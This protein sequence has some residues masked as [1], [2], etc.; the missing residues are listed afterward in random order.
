LQP[1]AIVLD[2]EMQPGMDGFETC[3]RIREDERFTYIPI[4][5]VSAREAVEDSLSGYEAGGEDYI[6]KP[7][8]RWSW[9]AKLQKRVRSGA[10]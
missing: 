3:R 5:F 9:S 6:V 8:R 2:V 10:G 7:F 4:V 1:A